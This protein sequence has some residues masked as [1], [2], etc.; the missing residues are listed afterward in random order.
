MTDTENNKINVPRELLKDLV[1]PPRCP[2]C[3]KPL[4]ILDRADFYRGHPT[5][6]SFVHD[7][8]FKKF[9]VI[10]ERLDSAGIYTDS[11]GLFRY[12]GPVRVIMKKI[13]DSS[14]KEFCE[15]LGYECAKYLG[16]WIRE[17]GPDCFVPVP[18][19][20]E[21]MRKRGFNQAEEMALALSRYTGIPVNTTLLKRVSETDALKEK[22]E[23]ERIKS[24]MKAFAVTQKGSVKTKI[25]LVDDIFTTGATMDCCAMAIREHSDIR[26]ISALAMAVGTYAKNN[27]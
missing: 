21:K 4:D 9:E 5:G 22:S 23:G 24:L 6:R 26:D 19:H 14:R 20:P 1:F 13:K 27:L 25:M 11:R 18:V 15:F 16:D 8:C 3:E 17:V 12:E 7:G 10:S 2:V